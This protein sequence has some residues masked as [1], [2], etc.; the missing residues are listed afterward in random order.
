MALAL[1]FSREESISTLPVYYGSDD[2]VI[3]V[4]MMLRCNKLVIVIKLM[5]AMMR[6]E[7]RQ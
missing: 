3:R 1:A 4:K 2:R 6:Q 5:S 7:S